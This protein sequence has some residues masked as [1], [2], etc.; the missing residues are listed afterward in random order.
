MK[1]SIE[2]TV[3][4]I[5]AAKAAYFE[6]NPDRPQGRVRS[7]TRKP[8]QV[9]KAESRIRTAAW[10]ANLDARGRPESSTVAVQFLVSLIETARESGYEAQELPETRAAFDHMFAVMAER[11]FRRNEVEAVIKRL[12][13]RA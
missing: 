12:T 5:D 13:R 11:G 9:L 10:R 3:A 7:R 6:R 2:Q 4:S 1:T 8:A